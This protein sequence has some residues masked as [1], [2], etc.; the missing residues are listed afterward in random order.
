M[1]RYYFGFGP[2][3]RFS[4]KWHRFYGP[5]WAF[6]G[7]FCSPFWGFE[8]WDKE[9]KRKFLECWKKELE[10]MKKDIEEEIRE[11]EREL[12]ELK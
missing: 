4:R 6:W 3:F 11:I 7:H 9:E 12:S 8:M 10:E 1:R 2:F 5:S